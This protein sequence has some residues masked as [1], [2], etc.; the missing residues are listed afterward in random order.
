M[1]AMFGDQERPWL[2]QVEHLAGAV[3]VAMAAV[4]AAPQ[5]AQALG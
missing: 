3:A 5:L 1:G 2:R 4:S